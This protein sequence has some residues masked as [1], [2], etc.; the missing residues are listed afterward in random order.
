[1]KKVFL[2]G[3]MAF[4]AI[5]SVG[6]TTKKV[7]FGL[8]ANLNLA[9]L[10]ISGD[11]PDDIKIK[12][13]PGVS[14][15]GFAN[16]SFSKLFSIQPELMYSMQGAKLEESGGPDE[17]TLNLDYINIPVMFQYGTASGFYAESGPQVG[18][19]LSAKAKADGDS[20]DVKDEFN[21]TDFS[22]GLG[23]GYRMKSG[24]GFGARYNLGLSNLAKDVD[25]DESAKNRVFQIGLS[26]TFG[27]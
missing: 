27:K 23:L 16:I 25:D 6:Q 7:S 24:L 15:G 9:S 4:L 10:S 1:M 2:I 22:W 14:A 3:S 26:Y 19:L 21:K 20:E 17:G 8:K 11:V 5:A 12:S 13:K 18:F